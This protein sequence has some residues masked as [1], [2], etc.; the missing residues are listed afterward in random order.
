MEEKQYGY[1]SYKSYYFDYNIININS[2]NTV[3]SYNDKD[4]TII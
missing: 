2:H 1:K 4:Y 3:R